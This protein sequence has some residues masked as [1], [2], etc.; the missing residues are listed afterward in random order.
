M[1]QIDSNN[2]MLYMKGTPSEPKCG[3]S[4]QVVRILHSQGG[5][6]FNM[7]HVGALDVQLLFEN[8]GRCD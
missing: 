4:A 8:R 7:T 2:V 5:T 1:F 3:F 6:A